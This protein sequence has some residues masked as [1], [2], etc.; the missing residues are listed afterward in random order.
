MAAPVIDLDEPTFAT[1]VDDAQDF[2]R[3]NQIWI[4]IALGNAGILIPGWT[5]VPSG[6]TA[7][8][9]AQLVLTGPGSRLIKMAYSYTGNDVT[10]IVISYDKA[11]GAGYEAVA[12]GTATITYDG[13]GNWTGTT[14]A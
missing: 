11:L 6:G 12:S 13:S 9:P 1:A 4:I 10:G 3:D 5:A 8:K 14:W 2:I 7:A